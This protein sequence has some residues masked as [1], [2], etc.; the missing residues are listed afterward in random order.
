MSIDIIDKILKSKSSKDIVCFCFRGQSNKVN[1]DN[2]IESLESYLENFNKSYRRRLFLISIEF[3]Q[4]V[5]AYS[6]KEQIDNVDVS[7]FFFRILSNDEEFIIETGNYINLN[8]KNTLVRKLDSTNSF[9]EEQLIEKYRQILNTPERSTKGGAG[10]GFIDIRRKSN[11]KINY[12]IFRVK[13]NLFFIIF[14][15]YLKKF[16][17]E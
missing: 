15:V 1:L 17:Y 3:L 14:K 16:L 13:K 4:N 6:L 12:Q 8:Q 9:T 7:E 5:Y 10:L 2:V 11:S